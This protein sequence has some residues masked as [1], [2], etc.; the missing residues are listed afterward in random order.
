[1]YSLCIAESSNGSSVQEGHEPLDRCRKNASAKHALRK[2][3]VDA[4]AQ[5]RG[6]HEER[7]GFRAEFHAART[8]LLK[9]DDVL[10]SGPETKLPA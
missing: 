5:K 1:M 9:P 2:H 6:G 4:M 8:W 7:S 10:S 3:S